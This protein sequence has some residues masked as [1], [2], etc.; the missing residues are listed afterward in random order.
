M[1]G[2]FKE[3]HQVYTRPVTCSQQVGWWTKDKGKDMKWA[4][5]EK[6]VFPKSEMTS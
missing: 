1:L 2:I 3:P 6:H 4:K 5:V